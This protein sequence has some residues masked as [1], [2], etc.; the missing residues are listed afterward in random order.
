[1][2]KWGTADLPFCTEQ[3]TPVRKVSTEGTA[4]LRD[5]STDGDVLVHSWKVR[6]FHGKR[7]G[8]IPSPHG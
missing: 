5:S 3:Q 7:A 1:M 2:S 4:E 8:R 6:L